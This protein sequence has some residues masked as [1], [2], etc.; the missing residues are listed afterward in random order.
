MFY[1]LTVIPFLLPCSQR[2]QEE[3][4]PLSRTPPGTSTE[5]ENWSI[6]H[7]T[8]PHVWTDSVLNW[9]HG[10]GIGFHEALVPGGCWGWW[11]QRHI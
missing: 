7:R 4:S 5:S 1:S 6:L 2:I 9:M 10:Q 11:E 3:A 8:G